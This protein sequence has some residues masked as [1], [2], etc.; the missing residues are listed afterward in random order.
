M[1]P[2][3]RSHS[4]HSL[5]V[6]H[7]IVQMLPNKSAYNPPQNA[8]AGVGQPADS[9]FRRSSLST[10]GPMPPPGGHRAGDS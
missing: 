2:R 5:R 3:S 4:E 7:F 9:L 1:M 8:A 6:K 10:V